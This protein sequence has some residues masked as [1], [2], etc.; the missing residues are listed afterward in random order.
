M[1]TLIQKS[2]MIFLL[3]GLLGCG[4]V[5]MALTRYQTAQHIWMY[6]MT[7]SF[8][9]LITNDALLRQDDLLLQET[10][11]ELARLEGIQSVAYL[12]S[13]QTVRMHSD[14]LQLG[15]PYHK[16][17]RLEWGIPVQGD[18][19]I[20]GRW[21]LSIDPSLWRRK[22]RPFMLTL[23]G[24]VL[25]WGVGATLVFG[26]LKVK[27]LFEVSA[28]QEVE[29]QL[30]RLQKDLKAQQE[31]FQQRTKL[32][33]QRMEALLQ[34]LSKPTIVLDET[35]RILLIHPKV[36]EFL[37]VGVPEP[38]VG[39]SWHEVPWL[40]GLGTVFANSIES[41]GHC[42]DARLLPLSEHVI[43]LTE[44]IGSDAKTLTWIY[45]T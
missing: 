14:S 8:L 21:V 2:G 38:V 31:D 42:F 29:A 3:V 32:D 5:W 4:W 22:A 7:R 9:Q 16:K 18:E 45:L 10:V 23:I 17:S 41:L 20:Q 26:S 19:E 44:S 6:Q 37:P 24:V 25:V 13:D 15:R 28:R 43:V 30:T 39:M 27:S 35:Q 1:K 11:Q 40:A 33:H 34:Q 36:K 12:D